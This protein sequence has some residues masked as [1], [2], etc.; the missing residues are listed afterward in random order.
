VKYVVESRA[1]HT[2][3][4]LYKDDR[5]QPV[6]YCALH[7]F[8]KRIA[9]VVSGVLRCEMGMISAYRGGNINAEFVIPRVLGYIMSHPGRPFF[10]L[11]SFVHPSSY[12]QLTG[13]SRLRR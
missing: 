9:G 3:I 7:I 8:E 11:A 12:A 10:C 1:E 5:G 4:K 2:W 6:G 13:C